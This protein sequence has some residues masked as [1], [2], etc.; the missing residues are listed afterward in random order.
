MSAIDYISLIHKQ[1]SNEI[2][3][4]ETTVLNQWIEANVENQILAN[5][6]RLIWENTEENL[7][8]I[9]DLAIDLDVEFSF[10]MER[11]KADEPTTVTISRIEETPV[12]EIR[13]RFRSPQFWSMAAG[14]AL[15]IGLSWFFIS[16][17]KV[18]SNYAE[19]KTGNETK[20][21]LLADGTTVF[22]NANSTLKYPIEFSGD[23]RT[24]LLSGE[25]FFDVAK[26]PKH[27]FII[28]T[29]YENITVLGTSF[30]VRAYENETISEIS[31]STG[32][33][34]INSGANSL[35]LEPNQK[36]IVERSNKAL[37]M[38]TTA[39]LNELAWHTQTIQFSNTPL[40]E[41]VQEMEKFYNVSLR[42]ENKS[43]ENCAYTDSFGA[44][45]LA[46]ALTSI[47]KVFGITINQTANSD[48][49]L[50]GGDC[51]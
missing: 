48:Y 31:V 28:H 34:K 42:L 43:L 40:L 20:E 29:P 30:N 23:N 11:I 9:P 7:E 4:E 37:E 36:V 38:K 25:A 51:Q 49:V 5:E 16:Q 13:N 45:E 24:I 22:L 26:D 1:L 32:S 12:I 6:I 46:T 27:P 3:T 10:L 47:S 50:V 19:L 44:D 18:A 15:L 14:F 35:I 21:I 39:Q 8:L 17:N 33:V 2:S 41:V